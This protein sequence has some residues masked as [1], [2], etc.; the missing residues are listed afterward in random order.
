MQSTAWEPEGV[1]SLLDASGALRDPAAIAGLDL[2]EYYKKLVAARVLDLKLGR[3]GLPMWASSAGE[4]AVCVAVGSL[5]GAHDWV[6]VGNRDAA[7]GLTRG[8]ARLRYW[9]IMAMRVLAVA[10]IVF[11]IARPLMSGWRSV[12]STYG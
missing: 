3:L 2:R 1:E 12:I 7:V 6:Y 9:L 4:E 10:A 5:L 8:M 11:V